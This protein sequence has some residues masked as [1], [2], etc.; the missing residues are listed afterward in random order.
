MAIW[1]ISL[2]FGIFYGHLVYFVAI[3][4]CCTNKNLATLVSAERLIKKI[5]E[6]FFLILIDLLVGLLLPKKDTTKF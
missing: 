5:P 6:N 4:V 1:S 2:P 3:L